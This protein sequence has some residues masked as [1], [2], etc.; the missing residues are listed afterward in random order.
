MFTKTSSV[1]I[2]NNHPAPSKAVDSSVSYPSR[3][4]V[5]PKLEM[6]EPGDSDELEA[7]VAANEVMSGKVS[8]QISGGSVGGGLAVSTQM[9]SRLGSLQGGGHAM[10]DGLRSMMERGFSRDFSQ[11]RLHTDSEAAEM[12]GSISAKAFTHGNDIYFNKGQYSP[13]TRDGQRLVAHELAHVAQGGR[14]VARQEDIPPS[15]R[16]RR[17]N[18]L[19]TLRYC[20][21]RLDDLTEAVRDQEKSDNSFFGG[22]SNLF[23]R[24]GFDADELVGILQ[25]CRPLIEDFR[26]GVD[27]D[28]DQASDGAEWLLSMVRQVESALAAHRNGTI[29]HGERWVTT[30]KITKAAAFTTAGIL[31]GGLA[32]PAI[33]S[34]GVGTALAGAG[35]AG[36]IGLGAIT[37]AVV[38]G[39][40]SLVSSTATEL[41][42]EGVDGSG[43]VKNVVKETLIGAGVGAVTGGVLKS[44][45]KGPTTNMRTSLFM[46]PSKTTEFAIKDV[47][48]KY[49]VGA[50]RYV[51]GNV[52]FSS[53]QDEE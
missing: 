23:N 25:S 41:A 20:E 12:S 35:V 17:S 51:L 40:T 14:A 5:H 46:D 37:G 21:L 28:L 8:R 45:P 30:L 11:V 48:A 38:S 10:P 4:I 34:T 36:K 47:A 50:G 49:G 44:L 42:K 3:T 9:E 13:Q 16:Q 19:Q 39:G 27:V 1:D 26:K 22:W 43:S 32:A 29:E 53:D 24:D 31:A 6:T 2:K 15:L 18:V 33:A 52:S 7:D